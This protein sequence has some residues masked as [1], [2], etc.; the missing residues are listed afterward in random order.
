MSKPAD[1]GE[2]KGAGALDCDS[3]LAQLGG[4]FR[5]RVLVCAALAAVQVGL[6]HTTYIFLAA[7]VPYRLVLFLIPILTVFVRV[8][9]LQ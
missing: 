1:E 6:L 3:V 7:D 9:Q 4:W 5:A 2:T 8:N